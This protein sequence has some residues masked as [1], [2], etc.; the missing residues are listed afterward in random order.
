[1][2][3]GLDNSK[4]VNLTI[5]SFKSY[6]RKYKDYFIPLF[7]ILGSVML[8][9]LVII[10]QFQN[11]VLSRKE[12]EAETQKLNILKNNYNF[13]ISLDE[14][15]NNNDF[16]ILSLALPPNKDFTGI[17][18]A[19]STA[20]SKVGVGIGD[21]SF[22]LGDLS[23]ASQEGVTSNPF[24]KI[25]INLTGNAKLIT[26]FIN[27]LIKT[28]P[29]S[30]VISVKTNLNS[31]DL[32]IHF[33]FKPFPPQNISNEAPVVQIS[34]QNI[35]LIKQIYTWNNTTDQGIGFIPLSSSSAS[36]SSTSGVNSS[37]F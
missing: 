4:Q 26:N 33:Y 10:P 27:E 28:V 22:S 14:D 15:K 1:M 8:F 25:E 7:V 34:A 29:L 30:E 24:I 5:S 20:A 18:N 16:K 36:V 19:V 13:L 17:I 32:I 11:Y 2:E 31:S 35:N 12:F 21:F 6:I 3:L 9:V 23:K 37:P